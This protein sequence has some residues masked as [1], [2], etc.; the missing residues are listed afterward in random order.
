MVVVATGDRTAVPGAYWA[1]LGG[2][3]LSLVGVQAMAFAMAWVAAGHGG[4]FAALVLTA[5]TLPRILLL[6]VGGAVADRYGAWPVMLIADAA[7]VVV[8]VT[9]AVAVRSPVD[10]R[11]PM[12][13]TALAI[14]IVDAFYLPSSGSMPRRLVPPGALARAMSARHLAGQLAVFA[15]PSLGG[16]VLAVAGLAG[17]AL[18][19]AA[20][21]LVMLTILLL[22][23]RP[24]DLLRPPE[25]RRAPQPVGPAVLDGLRLGW[26]HHTL[27]PA[28]LVTGV[29]AGFLLPVSSLLV[30][31]LARERAWSPQATG[32]V[33]AA[34]AL[35]TAAVAVTVVVRGAL[36]R[37][38]VVAAAGLLVAAIG[39]ALL[40]AG[41]S[42]WSV[43]VAG[44]VPL[45]AAGAGVVVGAGSGLFATHV[46]PLIL[47]AAPVTHLARVQSV[48]VLVQ[49]LPLLATTN[50]LGLLAETTH[51]P[52][53]LYACAA[54]LATTALTTLTSATLRHPPP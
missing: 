17:V 31:L 24:G 18:A 48:L 36:S 4:R 28:L 43:P 39:V 6:L 29:A 51:P 49:S 46:G 45:A 26:R 54:V 38:G 37:P 32:A 10:P 20:T 1:W 15:G 11:L 19:N 41:D 3:A 34:V 42:A 53:V 13:L 12:L 30:P 44:G 33:V 27:R 7:M 16:L 21:F 47:A 23:R 50:L 8:T 5:I 9:L 52:A 35:G 40:A 22:L 25:D 2:T 14:G